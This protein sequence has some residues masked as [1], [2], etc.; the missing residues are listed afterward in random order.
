MADATRGAEAPHKPH[1]MIPSDRVE[2]TPVR[3]PNGDTVGE[4]KRLMIDKVSGNVA[5]AVL[6]F[7]GFLGLGERFHPIPWPALRYNTDLAAYELNISD[8]QLKTAP[9]YG[10]R[11]DFDWGDRTNETALHEYYKT[12]PYWGI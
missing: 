3:R 11:E 6:S 5:Y 2:G 12:A 9:S 10:T 7:G 8:E 4:I 1:S